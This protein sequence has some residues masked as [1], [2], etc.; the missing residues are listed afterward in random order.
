MTAPLARDTTLRVESYAVHATA[1][2]ERSSLETAK[3]HSVNDLQCCHDDA[4]PRHAWC[5]ARRAAVVRQPPGLARHGRW[6]WRVARGADRPGQPDADP[7]AGHAPPLVL[8]LQHAEDQRGDERQR[9]PDLEPGW[10]VAPRG[11]HQPVA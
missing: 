2:D 3:H 8:H 7:G 5:I 11:E 9:V 6:P 10:S 4:P 1:A